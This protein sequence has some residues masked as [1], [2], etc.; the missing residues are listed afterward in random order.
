MAEK[1]VGISE[2]WWQPTARL[3]TAS[4]LPRFLQEVEEDD[5]HAAIDP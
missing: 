1:S 4:G 3:R 2:R 5:P